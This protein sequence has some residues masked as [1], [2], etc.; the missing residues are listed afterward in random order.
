MPLQFPP[1]RY[2]IVHS[3]VCYSLF[4]QSFVIFLGGENQYN[5]LSSVF[6]TMYFFRMSPFLLK[7]LITFQFYNYN[8]FILSNQKK[9]TWKWRQMREIFIYI[10][11]WLLI[12][13]K[14]KKINNQGIKPKTN[15]TVI[16]LKCSFLITKIICFLALYCCM[17]WI[18]NSTN[19]WLFFLSSIT[20]MTTK[21]RFFYIWKTPL[22]DSTLHLFIWMENSH[23]HKKRFNTFVFF[24]SK[25][26]N[27]S[28]FVLIQK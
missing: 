18:H 17:N 2:L 19:P 24:L 26:L 28:V 20:Q 1:P 3:S 5:H 16:M 6:I 23:L 12:G 15:V 8:W 25:F 27:H 13:C 14:K 9:K 21:W 7:T 22:K 4:F 11:L 10:I